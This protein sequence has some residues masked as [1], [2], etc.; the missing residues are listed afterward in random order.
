MRAGVNS[1]VP[2]SAHQRSR[3]QLGVRRHVPPL[4][5]VEPPTRRP[6]KMGIGEFP[7]VNAP[8]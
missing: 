1:S 4:M 8:R 3:T 5:A 6:M 7:T 2:I